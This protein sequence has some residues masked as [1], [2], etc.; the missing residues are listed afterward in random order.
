VAYTNTESLRLSDPTRAARL[1]TLVLAPGTRLDLTNNTLVLGNADLASVM[2]LIK[3]GR[4]GGLWNGPGLITSSANADQGLAVDQTGDGVEVKFTWNGDVNLDGRINADDYFYIDQGFLQKPNP[5]VY[6]NG[7]FNFDGKID[8]DDY[9][10]I[11]QAFLNQKGVVL[12]AQ[13]ARAAL[14]TTTESRPS[15]KVFSTTRLKKPTRR[16]PL[17]C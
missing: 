6:H 2:A 12:S 3:S 11:D 10:M 14:T 7:D 17:R 13:R 15:A 5:P 1:A 16:R 9:F 8:A 4:N